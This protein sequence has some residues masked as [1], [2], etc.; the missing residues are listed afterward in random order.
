MEGKGWCCSSQ[1]EEQRDD[2]DGL[3]VSDLD[4]GFD[5]VPGRQSY[6]QGTCDDKSGRRRRR[7]WMKDVDLLQDEMLK[8]HLSLF[9]EGENLEK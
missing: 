1:E 8:I 7:G 9:G 6:L 4:D 3:M 5:T 2:D